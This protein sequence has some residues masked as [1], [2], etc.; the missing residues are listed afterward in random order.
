MLEEEVDGRGEE[1]IDEEVDDGRR[2]EAE[3]VVVRA[4]GGEGRG[5]AVG[6][7]ELGEDGGGDVEEAG[8][9]GSC[10]EWGGHCD[11]GVD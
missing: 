10:Y 7:K 1:R 8:L 11:G 2:V 3:R 9:D 5:G 6:G 4:G